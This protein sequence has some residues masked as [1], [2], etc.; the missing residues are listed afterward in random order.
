MYTIKNE[1]KLIPWGI[2]LR[3]KCIRCGRC[4]SL[5]RVRLLED[6]VKYLTEKYGDV[7][8]YIENEPY[9]KHK[10]DG[11]IFLT[12]ENGMAKCTIYE[13][14]PL[15]CRVYPFYIRKWRDIKRDI[16]IESIRDVLFRYR[17][18]KYGVYVSNI[19]MGLGIGMPIEIEIRKAIREK[20]FKRIYPQKR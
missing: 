17:G 3:W 16:P 7:V 15:V 13:D 12:Y 2:F 19:C 1:H 4:C 18:R 6:E 8:E 9:L 20:Y 14:R 5:L 11:C 10:S